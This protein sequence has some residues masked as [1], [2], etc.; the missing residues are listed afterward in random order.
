MAAKQAY[1][2]SASRQTQRMC[3]GKLPG[4]DASIAKR[5]LATLQSVQL[6]L[7]AS[8]SNWTKLGCDDCTTKPSYV[9]LRE[10]KTQFGQEYSCGSEQCTGACVASFQ[11][12]FLS[13]NIKFTVPHLDT[14]IPS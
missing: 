10:L 5:T 12:S 4:E 7:S 3:L 8:E 11:V 1:L 2:S 6:S 14:K 9:D 13:E